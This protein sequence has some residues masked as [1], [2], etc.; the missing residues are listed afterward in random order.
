MEGG[1]V[2]CE[3]LR[4]GG[5]LQPCIRHMTP[6]DEKRIG[7][8]LGAFDGVEAVYLFGSHVDGNV[9]S[10]S[11]IDLAIVPQTESVR[12]SRLEMLTQVTRAGFDNIDIVFLEERD[13][14]LQFHAIRRNRPIYQAPRFDHPAYF[15]RTISIYE[16]LKPLLRIQQQAYKRQVLGG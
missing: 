4:A 8:I 2:F 9:R 7:G 3:F 14:V 16:D 6:E 15:S 5:S 10:D 1:P 13:L 12:H 11:D